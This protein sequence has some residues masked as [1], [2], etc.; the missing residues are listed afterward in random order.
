MD[1]VDKIEK[2]RFLGKELLV[3]LWFESEVFEGR[4]ELPGFARVELYL[5]QQ[6]TLADGKEQSRLSGSSPSAWTEAR[7]ALRQGKLPTSAKIRVEVGDACYAFVLKAETLGLSGVR[8]PA[9]AKDEGDDAFYDR[10][11]R[12]EELDDLLLAL[13]GAY[14][15][16]RLSP[17]FAGEIL[18]AMRAWVRGDEIDADRYARARAQAL[19]KSPARRSAPASTPPPALEA[20]RPGAAARVA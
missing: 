13:F 16:R 8:L 2:L 1:T 6:L 19:S 20:P 11:A 18:P 17:L 14:S 3:W 7:E 10:M 12:I 9:I 15:A 5:E 4:I